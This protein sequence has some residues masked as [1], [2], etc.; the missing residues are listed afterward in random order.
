MLVGDACQAIGRRHAWEIVDHLNA[1]QARAAARRLEGIQADHVPF[2]DTMQEEEWEGQAGLLELMQQHDWPG[3]MG[4][5]SNLEDDG[6][7]AAWQKKG[8]LLRIRLMGKRTIMANYTRYMNQ[9]VANA[10]Q[11]YAAHPADPPIPSD[12]MSQILLPVFTK[13]RFNDARSSTENALLLTLLALRA[14][15][16]DHGAYPA[17]L[18]ALAPNYLKAVPDDPFALSGPL[19]YKNLGSKYLLYSVG[20]DGKDDGGKP[21]FDAAKPA[22]TV[23]G[24]LD[25]R[26]QMEAGS[27]GDIV[28]G[29]NVN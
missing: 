14:Y 20:P 10:R 13:V 27:Q 1:A 28:A 18:S 22:P 9:E 7:A 23:P 6:M 12:P 19:R 24:Y 5:L 17:A 15:R 3:N 8:Y 2:A 16:L 21:I 11:P 25:Q 4:N 29:V 26:Y